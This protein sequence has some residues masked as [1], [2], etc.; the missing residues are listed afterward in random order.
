MIKKYCRKCGELLTDDNWYPSHKKAQNKICIKCHKIIGKQYRTDNNEDL[1]KKAR[2]YQ[3]YHREENIKRSHDYYLTHRE[4]SKQYYLDR[5]KVILEK[6][7]LDR[8]DDPEKFR[9]RARENARKHGVKPFDE[10]KECSSYFGVH[11]V[12]RILSKIFKDIKRMPMTNSGFDF[13][14]NKGYKVDSKASC[15]RVSKKDNYSDRW[16]FA[17]RQNIIADYFLCVAFDNRDDLNPE[18]IWL[19]PGH[20]IN[21]LHT[22]SI[23]ESR[24]DKWDDY[25][26]DKIDE[27]LQCCDILRTNVD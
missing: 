15:R 19:I 18:H 21:H 6:K 23:T 5:R 13:L 16:M 25:K 14:C 7:R 10:N 1:N 20:Y 2:E 12:E 11:I 4:E 9:D 8:I 22:L 24:L 3:R 17:I 27:L 26:I